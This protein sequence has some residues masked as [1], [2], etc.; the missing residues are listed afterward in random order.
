MEINYVQHARSRMRRR[1]IT[2]SDV[3]LTLSDPDVT[4]P[5]PPQPGADRSVIFQRRIGNRTCK[6]YVLA[7]IE[8]PLVVT[9]AWQDE[10]WNQERQP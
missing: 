9:V 6:V 7:E 3:R 5:A 8:P 1:G 10:K 2:E 4:R